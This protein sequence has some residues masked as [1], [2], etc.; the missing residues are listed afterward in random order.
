MSYEKL[1]EATPKELL[2]AA[3]YG[4]SH[5]SDDFL[6]GVELG[7]KLAGPDGWQQVASAWL[8]AVEKQEETSALPARTRQST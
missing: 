5:A 8:R 4:Y 7:V 3:L 1:R 2:A 6:R